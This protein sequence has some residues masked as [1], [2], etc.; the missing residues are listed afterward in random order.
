MIGASDFRIPH[1]HT[2]RAPDL[3]N[4]SAVAKK[5]A[6][7]LAPDPGIECT[8]LRRLPKQRRDAARACRIQAEILIHADSDQRFQIEQTGDGKSGRDEIGG[9]IR[10]MSALIGG[11]ETGRQMSAR[12]MPAGEEPP[13]VATP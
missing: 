4:G 10:R 11:N 6:A 1:R 2:L 8:A 3:G 12:G 13:A 9:Q 7:L 5:F